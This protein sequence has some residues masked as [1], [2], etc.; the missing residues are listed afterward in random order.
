VVKSPVTLTIVRVMSRMRSTPKT[1]PIAA[2]GTSVVTEAT[3]MP[4]SGSEPPGT[5][6][7]PV[8]V[9]TQSSRTINSCSSDRSTPKIWQRKIAV[10][11]SKSAVPLWFID[12]LKGSTNRATRGGTP[13]FSS[14]VWIAVGSVALD[15]LVLNA[16]IIA[17]FDFS[18]NTSGF[19]PPSVFTRIGKTTKSWIASPPS[20]VPTKAPRAMSTETPSSAVVVKMSAKT[21]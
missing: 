11:A 16:V 12:A 20:T 10:T 9:N 19:M 5:P 3:T 14:A 17:A 15:E 18:K 2:A 6:A 1:M 4:I 8:A 21:P 7:M 13:R